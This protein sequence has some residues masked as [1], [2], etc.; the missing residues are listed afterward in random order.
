MYSAK[1]SVI[2]PVYNG[3]AYI[4]EC[5]DSILAQTLTEIEII[6]VD[7]GSTDGTAELLQSYAKRDGRIKLLFSDKKSM[8]YQ[9]NMGIQAATGEYIGFCEAD[10]FLAETMYGQLYE[11]A[12]HGKLDYVK[13]DFHMFAGGDKKIC[14]NY[15]ILDSPRAFLYNT[16]FC[17]RD[18]PDLVFR[19]VNMWNGIYRRDFIISNSI[20]LNET[21]KA[22]F[23]DMGFVIQT[24]AFS[25]QVMYVQKAANWYRRD[26]EYSSVYDRKSL[27]FVLWESE[28]IYRICKKNKIHNKEFL[29]AVLQRFL[30]AFCEYYGKLPDGSETKE[31]ICEAVKRF[32]QVLRH[33]YHMLGYSGMRF[34]NQNQLFDLGLLTENNRFFYSYRKAI[35]EFHKK[36]FSL[37]YE[38]VC[39][40]HDVIIFGAGEC[41]AVCYILLKNNGYTNIR[42]FCDN[43]TKLWG[44]TFMG[45]PVL[46]VEEAVSLRTED[47]LFIIANK[48]YGREMYRQLLQSGV[49]ERSICMSVDIGPHQAFEV[50]YDKKGILG[51]RENRQGGLEVLEKTDDQS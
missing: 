38:R 48:A 8:G 43:N 19:D 51:E 7:A 29:A 3:M 17:P 6:P 25:D 47:T 42:C 5:M 20:Q 21:P 34:F 1:V 49:K 45:A 31:E 27:L 32:G 2:I 36:R 50:I 26:N 44:G 13:S 46:S 15:H 39:G 10:D 14:L 40:F 41:G 33:F 4:Q 12:S 22:A 16:V 24:L 18:I 28:Y 23:Q 11:A 37:F 9:T 30:S 35:N